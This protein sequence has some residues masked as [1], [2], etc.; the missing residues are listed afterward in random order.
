MT[1]QSDFRRKLEAIKN[2]PADQKFT[3]EEYNERMKKLT[4]GRTR[5]NFPDLHP[6]Q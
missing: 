2:I 3:Q 1:E 4:A 6:Y 5:T